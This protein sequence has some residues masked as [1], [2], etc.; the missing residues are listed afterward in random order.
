MEVLKFTFL[1][2]KYSVRTMLMK[3]TNLLRIKCLNISGYLNIRSSRLEEYCEKVFLT[4]LQNSLKNIKNIRDAVFTLKFQAKRS[5]GFLKRGS[6]I[7][8][9]KEFRRSFKNTYFAEHRQTATSETFENENFL[10]PGF[11]ILSNSLKNTCK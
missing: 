7:C 4:F 3:R 9:S 1:L 11:K 5:T 6:S 10:L 2:I 8:A